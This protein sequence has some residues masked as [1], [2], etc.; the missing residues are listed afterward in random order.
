MKI[1]KRGLATRWALKTNLARLR[2][3]ATMPF[4]LAVYFILSRYVLLSS[5]PALKR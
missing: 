5:L 2:L 1:E 4:F 3:N